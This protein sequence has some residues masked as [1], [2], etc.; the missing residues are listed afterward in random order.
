[1]DEAVRRLKG[2]EGSEVKLTVQHPGKKAS[3]TVTVRR[4]AIHIETVFGD[5]RGPDD[6]WDYLSTPKTGSPTSASPPSA[7]TRRTSSATPSKSSRRRRS[8]A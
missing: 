4:E 1:M 2:A 3:E 5:H 7:A 6:A 8:A